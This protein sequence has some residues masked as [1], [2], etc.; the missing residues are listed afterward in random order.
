MTR[1]NDGS[2]PQGVAIDTAH[3]GNTN[4]V[5]EEAMEFER[6]LE[7]ARALLI[8]NPLCRP[9]LYRILNSCVSKRILLGDLE[10][11]IQSM[12]EYQCV[13]QPPYFLVQWLVDTEAL[14]LFELDLAGD[15][16]TE[17]S[18][19]GLTA[20]EIDDRIADYAF[21]TNDVGRALIEELKPTNRLEDLVEMAPER[22]DTYLDVLEFLQD[23]HS[24]AEID[25]LLRGR[26]I[27]MYGRAADDRPMQPS[28]F[29][30]K[31]AAAG[32]IVYSDGWKITEEGKEFLESRRKA[33]K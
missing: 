32:S 26:D 2:V 1:I 13:T 7:K 24:Y 14:D 16:V 18:K 12:T 6:K 11:S 4:I 33:N 22:Y 28:V 21:E 3:F 10:N 29:V 17:E 5:F 27:L 9:V 31:L 23:P 30:D 15:T 20:D 25:E 19:Q 8:Q